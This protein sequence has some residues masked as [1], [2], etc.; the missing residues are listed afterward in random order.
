MYFSFPH[1]N[2]RGGFLLLEIMLAVMIFSLSVVALGRC[3][4]DCLDAQQ[5]RIREEHARLALENR[6]GE[7]QA[8]PA[9]PDE[10]RRRTLEG[11]FTGMTMLER[12]RTLDF[13]N[14]DNLVMSG[15]HEITLT[16]EWKDSGGQQSK[17][18]TFYLLR[19]S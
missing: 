10:S 11:M 18:I 6:M 14:E 2:R 1:R 9:L 7:L 12:R 13:K 19:G 15:L 5:A 16:A 17:S 4:S 3:M 8:S